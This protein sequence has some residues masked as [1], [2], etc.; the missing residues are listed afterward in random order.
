MLQNLL[1]QIQDRQSAKTLV[2]NREDGDS[3]NVALRV[4]AALLDKPL[5]QRINAIPDGVYAT[6]MTGK[7]RWQSGLTGDR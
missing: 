2:A 7:K 5:P 1:F 4:M 3:F 6:P